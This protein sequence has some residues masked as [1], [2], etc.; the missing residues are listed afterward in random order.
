LDVQI[1]LQ[2]S[3][4]YNG[5]QQRAHF[6]VINP[7]ALIVYS[8]IFFMQIRNISHNDKKV[9]SEIAELVG[10]PFSWFERFKMGGNRSPRFRL[11]RASTPIEALLAVDNRRW[12]CN[13]EL[14]PTGI[15]LAFRSLSETYAWIVP[16]RN[17]SL[18]KSEDY[19]TLYSAQ[20][21]AKLVWDDRDKGAKKFLAKLMSCK[22]KVHKDEAMPA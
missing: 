12:H 4:F 8:V 21:F 22:A 3:G 5:F 19:L 2:L 13:I 16:Y 14:R 17:L 11:I 1:R 10:E 9:R 18:F 20:Y 7:G 15:L 6:S